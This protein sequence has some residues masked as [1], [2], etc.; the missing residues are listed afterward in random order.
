MT[1]DTQKQTE[2]S[3]HFLGYVTSTPFKSFID[4]RGYHNGF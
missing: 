2:K 4:L 1:K 3:S